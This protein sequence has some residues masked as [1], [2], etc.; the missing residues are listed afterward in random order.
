MEIL[1]VRTSISNEFL[2]PVTKG[3]TYIYKYIHTKKKTTHRK[4]VESTGAECQKE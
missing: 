3:G 2:D 1:N 4:Y